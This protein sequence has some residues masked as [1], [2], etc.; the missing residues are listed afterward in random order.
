[1]C[2]AHILADDH[3]YIPW[4][5]TCT[6]R[7]LALQYIVCLVAVFDRVYLFLIKYVQFLIDQKCHL[8]SRHRLTYRWYIVHMI[9]VITVDRS[10]VDFIIKTL[11]CDVHR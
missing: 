4:R 3:M 7:L 1:M 9:V 6:P 8:L 10:Q 5:C 11:M 2:F